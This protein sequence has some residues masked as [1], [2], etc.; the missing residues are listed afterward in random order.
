MTNHTRNDILSSDLDF[1]F[2]VTILFTLDVG[3]WERKNVKLAELFAFGKHL[4]DKN[5]LLSSYSINFVVAV[6]VVLRSPGGRRSECRDGQA[7]T[8]CLRFHPP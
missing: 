8:L 5:C 2:Y 1:T 7:G 6:I 3:G 4:A